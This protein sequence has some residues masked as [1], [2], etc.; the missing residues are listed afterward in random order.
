MTI[1]I[2]NTQVDSTFNI[3]EL[4]SGTLDGNGVF[5]GILKTVH[6]H[7]EREYE[8]NRIR[9]T[10]YA[11]AY[12]QLMQNALQQSTSYAI[13]KAKLPLELQLLEAE[14]QKVATDTIVA[15][16]QGG[17]IDA[18][19]LHTMAQVKK[20]QFEITYLLPKQLALTEKEIAL[21]QNQ[22]DLGIKELALKDKQL[23]IAEKEIGIKEQQLKLAEYEFN[24][25]APAEVD[26]IK[27]QTGLYNQKKVTEKAQT[28]P[29]VI[30]TGSVVDVQ[31]RLH[32]KQTESYDRD[33][34]QKLLSIYADT[35]KVRY[36]ADPE[37]VANGVTDVNKLADS[38]IGKIATKAFNGINVSI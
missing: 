11:N 26:S 34:E 32:Q 17:L 20:L 6:A 29:S 19:S 24:F 8:R 30:G 22:I 37:S 5:D 2:P 14:I 7:L 15:T 33:A 1:T 25:K 27:A 36:N 38:F 3:S 23:A 35:W 9:G 13:H 10:D 21:K 18:Q 28:D 12:V 4:T 16:K 31:N